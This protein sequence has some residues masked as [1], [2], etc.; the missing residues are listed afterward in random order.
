MRLVLFAIAVWFGLELLLLAALF[1]LAANEE[2]QRAL[3][4]RLARQLT[5]DRGRGQGR[6]APAA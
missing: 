5:S 2:R 4:A 1:A 3:N 6:M